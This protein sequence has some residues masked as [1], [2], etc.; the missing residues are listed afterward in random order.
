MM[1]FGFKFEIIVKVHCGLDII[2]FVLSVHGGLHLLDEAVDG[3]VRHHAV[4][5]DPAHLTARHAVLAHRLLE[6]HHLGEGGGVDAQ[7]ADGFEGDQR[8]ANVVILHATRF[9]RAGEVQLDGLGGTWGTASD[10]ILQRLD[11]G[12]SRVVLIVQGLVH[13]DRNHD[14]ILCDFGILPRLEDGFLG[15]GLGFL[16][17]GPEVLHGLGEVEG[18]GALLGEGAEDHQQLG[19]VLGRHPARRDCLVSQHNLEKKSKMHFQKD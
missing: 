15:R 3:L 11:L 14:V 2:G 9:D 16:L 17:Q 18:L 13:P 1:G 8:L 6:E 7:G 5:E 19:A 4:T 12:P 10:N